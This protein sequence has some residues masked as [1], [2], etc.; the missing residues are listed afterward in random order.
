MTFQRPYQ[1]SP[2][3]SNPYSNYP[4]N[5]YSNPYQPPSNR[6]LPT[7]H[8]PRLVG[9]VPTTAALGLR[10]SLKRRAAKRRQARQGER[11]CTQ[12]AGRSLTRRPPSNQISEA[13]ALQRV[14]PST[15]LCTDQGERALLQGPRRPEGRSPSTGWAAQLGTG[16]Q[17]LGRD[18]GR[19]TAD[20]HQQH[21]QQIDRLR[22]RERASG[23]AEWLAWAASCGTADRRHR[24][25]RPPN[26]RHRPSYARRWRLQI[27]SRCFETRVA[28][29]LCTPLPA[30]LRRTLTG[31]LPKYLLT[32]RRHASA[33]GPSF[34]RI[35]KTAFSSFV[36]FQ[37]AYAPP[38]D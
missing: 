12:W 7:P 6:V 28:T 8:T 31:F 38:S 24:H 2:T 14:R 19:K 23:A 4:A 34:Q 30:A 33:M 1:R 18:H 11:A 21:R 36:L 35:W 9:S 26:E 16:P 27:L 15:G 5:G 17:L 22:A 3:A 20:H 13:G 32:L 37:N 10:G 25:Q 29:P